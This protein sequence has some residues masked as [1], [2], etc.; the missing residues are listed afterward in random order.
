[1]LKNI[2]KYIYA[3]KQISLNG[4]GATGASAACTTSLLSGS[5]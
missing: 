1:M 3:R 2:N 4:Q 5:L